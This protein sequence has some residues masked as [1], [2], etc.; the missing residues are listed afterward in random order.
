MHWNAHFI[1]YS[2][3]SQ[4][5]VKGNKDNTTQVQRD[6]HTDSWPHHNIPIPSPE[7]ITLQ[8]LHSPAGGLM[9]GSTCRLS[10]INVRSQLCPA[11]TFPL[12]ARNSWSQCIL[13]ASAR[14]AE[15]ALH[16][17]SRV[18]SEVNTPLRRFLSREL[19]KLVLKR[20]CGS[21]TGGLS[22]SHRLEP[23]WSFTHDDIIPIA[24]ANESLTESILFS[25]S[26]E[27]AALILE[28]N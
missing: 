22:S 23:A 5:A 2:R 28:F 10:S 16:R 8:T 24:H 20:H 25:E 21:W 26:F 14:R 7:I 17:K 13:R 27:P 3:K 1:D 18:S 12:L 15:T 4:A 11:L 6:W 9:I 19:P